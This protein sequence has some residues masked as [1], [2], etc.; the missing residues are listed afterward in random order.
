MA[1]QG[2]VLTVSRSARGPTL[3][4]TSR[5]TVLKEKPESCCDIVNR[6]FC[7]IC[8]LIIFKFLGRLFIGKGDYRRLAVRRL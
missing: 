3:M 8:I 4:I 2:T 6:L 1:N 5:N 7:I